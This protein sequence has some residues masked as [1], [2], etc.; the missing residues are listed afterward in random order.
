MRIVGALL[1]CCA[2]SAPSVAGSYYRWV[3]ENGVVHFS[4]SPPE[5]SLE[6]EIELKDI[7]LST[8]PQVVA[9]PSPDAPPVPPEPE[10]PSATDVLLLSPLDEETIRNNEGNISLSL[11]TDLPLGKGQS[12][13]AVIDGKAQKAQQGLSIELNNVDRGEHAIKVQLL[14]DG[15][16]IATSK[17]VTVFLHRN[18]HRKTP[19]KATPKPL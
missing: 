14:Q 17:S 11:T 16:V 6:L 10:A 5:V 19:P 3:D 1:L 8:S 12:V 18:I 9:P 4:D 15:K 13:R 7:P 2:I